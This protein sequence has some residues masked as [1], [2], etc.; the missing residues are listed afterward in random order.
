DRD[1]GPAPGLTKQ[2]KRSGWKMTLLGI[3]LIVYASYV[4]IAM[5]AVSLLG[6]SIMA[7]FFAATASSS[8]ANTGLGNF[9]AG[10]LVYV[11]ILLLLFLME[12]AFVVLQVTGH[13]FCLA[14]PH[15]IG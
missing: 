1:R 7:L 8:N 12:L 3:N 15:Q 13:G 5:V 10:G 9:M 6:C 14:A 11:L 4:L 2:Q